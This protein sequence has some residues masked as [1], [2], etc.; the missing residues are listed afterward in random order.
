MCGQA[1]DMPTQYF[2]FFGIV[3]PRYLF[4]VD[5][6]ITYTLASLCEFVNMYPTEAQETNGLLCYKCKL[7]F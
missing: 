4:I 2:Y 6:V 1:Q 5:P 3:L 7:I